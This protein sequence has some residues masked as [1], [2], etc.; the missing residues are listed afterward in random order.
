MEGHSSIIIAV[1]STSSG[2]GKTITAIN[3][4]AGLAEEG[5]RTCLVDLDLQFGDVMG[6]LDLV[7]DYTIAD[8]QR[9]ILRD[10][11]H[12]KIDDYLTEY[13]CGEASFAVLPPPREINDAYQIN[14]EAVAKIIRS[15][16][17]FNFIVLDLTAVFSTLNLAMLDLSTVINYVGVM[18][19]LPAVKNYKVGYDTLL[20]F[21]YEE[22]KICLVENMTDQDR[23]I[24]SRDVERLLGTKI[25]HHLPS[26]PQA[27]TYSIRMGKPLM[28][29]V[30]LSP[31]TQSYW[32]LV[33]RY[34]NRTKKSRIA[35]QP[36]QELKGKKKILSWLFGEDD[37]QT[38]QN[39]K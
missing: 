21:D 29:C 13:K 31:L 11:Q 2:N 26:D 1:F 3:L 34:T 17:G 12:F 39:M 16:R 20:R 6:Y 37:W 9:A 38:A 32:E 10:E 28:Y 15:M 36:K 8:A 27:I 33:G 30:P 18:D 22:S 19:F 5:Y 23:Y 4:A 35:S 14:V 25:Y 24:K 7:S